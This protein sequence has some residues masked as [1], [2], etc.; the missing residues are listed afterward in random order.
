MMPAVMPPKY[1]VKR[2][3]S[4]R[5]Y[6]ENTGLCEVFHSQDQESEVLELLDVL[7]MPEVGEDNGTQMIKDS[8]HNMDW[9]TAKK[10]CQAIKD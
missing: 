2:R 7:Q 10:F 6:N 4:T 3:I 8:F 5:I 1:S 9:N